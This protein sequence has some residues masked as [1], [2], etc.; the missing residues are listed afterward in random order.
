MVRI[1]KALA[2]IA[3][4]FLPAICVH[5]RIYLSTDIYEHGALCGD[6]MQLLRPVLAHELSLTKNKK[7]IVYAVSSYESPLR[8]LIIAKAGRNVTAAYHMGRIMAAHDIVPEIPCDI[9]VP[10]PLHWSRRWWRGYNQAEIMAHEIARAHNLGVEN[11]LA[12]VKRTPFQ[13]T[14]P[15]IDRAANVE[16][17]FVCTNPEKVRDKHIVLIDDLMTT[18]ATLRQVARALIVHRPA[19]IAAFVSARL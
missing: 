9:L 13:S 5:C 2:T 14:L 7:M 12:R 8:S 1:Q 6:C 10:V 11:V 3:D 15:I 17:A 16:Q 19:S 18:G 4:Y